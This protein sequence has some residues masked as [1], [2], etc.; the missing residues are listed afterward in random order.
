[1]FAF[2][3]FELYFQHGGVDLKFKVTL[4]A[5][6]SPKTASEFVV[7][8]MVYTQK[9]GY[10]E[11]LRSGLHIKAS[12]QQEMEEKVKRKLSSQ[13]RI[14]AYAAVLQNLY[15]YQLRDFE[16]TFFYNKNTKSFEEREIQ[17]K[18]SA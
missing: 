8:P 18:H 13:S 6:E 9:M 7:C 10:R 12:S 16:D 17:Y 1:M 3:N 14:M 4:H 5:E 2:E 15:E 11:V